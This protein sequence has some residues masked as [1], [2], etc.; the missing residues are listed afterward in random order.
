MKK[1]YIYFLTLFFLF[2]FFKFFENTYIIL[3]NDYD[4]RLANEY[5]FCEKTSYGFIKHIDKKYKLKKNIKIIND[6][7]HPSSDSFIHK[8]NVSYSDDYLI[9]LNYNES[10][11]KINMA[12][13]TVI[14]KIKNCYY[15]IKND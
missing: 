3:K 5:G 7:S 9:L 12:N 10:D 6:E 2:I 8:P 14:E 11:S 1:K 15:L 13:F 4:L